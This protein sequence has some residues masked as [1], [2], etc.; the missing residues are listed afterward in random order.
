MSKLVLEVEAKDLLSELNLEKVID[1]DI[2]D[3]TIS[4]IVDDL[5]A[6]QVRTPAITV[7]TIDAAIGNLTRSIQASGESILSVLMKL[8]DTAGGYIEV[9]NDRELN[10]TVSIGEDKGQQIRYAKNLLGIERE[11][12]YSQLFNRIYAYGEGEGEAKIVL[13]DAEGQDEDYV[14]DTDSQTTW[15]GIYI[16]IFKDNSITHPDTLLA[17]ANQLKAEY[18]TPPITYR[19]NS[20]D[21][22]QN[23]SF[24]ALQLGSTITVIDEDLGIDVEVTVVDIEHPNL[25]TNPYDMNLELATVVRDI[26]DTLTEVYDNLQFEKHIATK[27]GA[28]QVVVLGDFTVLDWATE[29]KTTIHG[30]NIETGTITADKLF[31]DYIEVGG[32]ASDVNANATTIS[33]GKITT[34]TLEASSLKASSLSVAISTTTGG[35]IKSGTGTSRVE[36]TPDGIRAYYS[37]NQRVQISADGSGWLGSSGALSWTTAGVLTVAAANVSGA[38]TAATIS[39]TKISAGNLAATVIATCN[40][41]AGQITAG[42]LNCSLITVSN[43]SATSINTGTLNC[44]L[45]TVSNLSATSINTGTLNCS[46]ITVSNLSA[47]S[48][49]TGTL[50]CTKVTVSSLSATSI[51][52]GTLDCT[53]VTV[54]DL[55]ATSITS[56]TLNCSLITVSNLS[57]DSITSGTLSG[58][59]ISGGTITGTI[60]SQ[61]SEAVYIS[62]TGLQIRGQKL[63]LCHTDGSDPSYIYV[64]ASGIMQFL[65]ANDAEFNGYITADGFYE[66][67][68]HLPE[69]DYVTA[70]KKVKFKADGGVDKL[71]LPRYCT[72]E[73][74]T[75]FEMGA[76]VLS[77]TK[78]VQSLTER[79]EALETA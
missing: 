64:D 72:N 38:L 62:S 42:T 67:S 44:S 19:V 48:I 39:A 1:Y 8:R 61:A 77:L 45:I 21:L 31:A 43:L 53:K 18:S 29:G 3:E 68:P 66:S 15:G 46:L 59:R 75:S 32:A 25:D 69:D 27:I 16:G 51:T 24:D 35:A 23:I 55:S 79:I 26:T 52:S 71:S 78:V 14:E 13:S 9:D 30:D 40:L 17:W 57:A 63:K 11:I 28:G 22:G 60:F 33:G 34:N 41:S 76:M 47:T 6:M 12:D 4:N 2:E 74:Q 20:I 54:S 49:T 50:D 65:T 56:G 37:N 58:D 5:L 73:S 10:W 36:I 7:G 70:F